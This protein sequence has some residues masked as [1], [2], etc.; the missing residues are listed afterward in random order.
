MTARQLTV[1]LSGDG[2][3]VLIL[4]QPLTL[5][6]LCRLEHSL[7][8]SLAKLRREIGSDAADPGILEYESWMQ[9]L[10]PI[11]P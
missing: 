2:P 8:G 3:A 9:H 6:S 11:R 4:P 10:R 5:E 1:P 7:A